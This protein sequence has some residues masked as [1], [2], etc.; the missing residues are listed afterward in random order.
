MEKQG[1]LKE[2]RNEM[3]GF[4][5]RDDTCREGWLGSRMLVGRARM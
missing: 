5:C 3:T 4:C 2:T 1:D